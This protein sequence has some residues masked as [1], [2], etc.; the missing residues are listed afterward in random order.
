MTLLTP[1]PSTNNKTFDREDSKIST[2][3]S[4]ED[5]QTTTSPPPMIST[6]TNASAF[7][8]EMGSNSDQL[9]FVTSYSDFDKLG[10]SSCFSLF[11]CMFV[12][13]N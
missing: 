11:V 1:P 7:T 8:D 5:S 10:K 9:F 12:D 2:G 3:S 13:L 4:S 6:T